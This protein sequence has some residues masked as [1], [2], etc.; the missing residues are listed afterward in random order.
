MKYIPKPPILGPLLF[1]NSEGTGPL[2]W[3]TPATQDPQGTWVK[4]TILASL[5]KAHTLQAADINRDGKI[6][7]V[8]GQMHTSADREVMILYNQDGLGTAW[9][10]QVIGT[11][12]IH[13]GVVADID[14]DGDW[15]IFGANW[16]GY[17]PIRLWVNQLPPLPRIYL[18]LLTR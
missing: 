5:E 7:L 9:Q 12:G 13:N 1:S 15:D 4:T 16:T 8:V 2:A 10:K 6:D 3:W 18:P 14:N 11:G 17:P